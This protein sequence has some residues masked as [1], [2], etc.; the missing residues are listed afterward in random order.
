MYNNP[1]RPFLDA[2]KANVEAELKIFRKQTY[3]LPGEKIYAMAYEIRLCETMARMI[4]DGE[5]F[6][7]ANSTVTNVV[8]RL[9][10]EGVF[11]KRFVAWAMSREKGIDIRDL[12]QVYDVLLDFAYGVKREET[13]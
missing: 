4:R 7:R 6:Y 13:Q 10:E 9:S 3:S 8:F 2:I 12:T 11:L 1:F 5:E